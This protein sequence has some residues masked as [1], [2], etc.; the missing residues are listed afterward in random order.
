MSSNWSSLKSLKA[1]YYGFC[2][3]AFF[4]IG[5][6]LTALVLFSLSLFLPASLLLARDCL[7]P[8]ELLFDVLLRANCATIDGLELVVL[9]DGT[10]VRFVREPFA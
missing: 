7:T 8:I 1:I 10:C 4:S 9:P 2:S 6:Y 3:G 5:L